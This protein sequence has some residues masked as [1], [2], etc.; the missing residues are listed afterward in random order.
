MAN[1]L[2]LVVDDYRD[3]RRGLVDVL[4]GA[5]FRVIAAASAA[6]AISAAT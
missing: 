3:L 6:E 4:E 1:E 2:I 5:G